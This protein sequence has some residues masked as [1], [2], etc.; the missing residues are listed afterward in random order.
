MTCARC[1]DAE[2]TLLAPCIGR[3]KSSEVY[4]CIHNISQERYAVK[5][6]S[7][8]RSTSREDSIREMRVMVALANAPRTVRPVDFFDE[9]HRCLLVMELL[10]G[11]D[12]SQHIDIPEITASGV[13]KNVLEAL[14]AMHSL[15]IAHRDLKLENVLLTCDDLTNV[16][17]ADFGFAEVVP[18]SG[19]R[20]CSGTPLYIAPEVLLSGYYSQRKCHAATL[21][22]GTAC[23]MWSIGV[24]TYILICGRAPFVGDTLEEHFKRIVAGDV[25]YPATISPRARSFLAGL[26]NIN[27][28]AR[29]TAQRA[30][31]HPWVRL[32]PEAVDDESDNEHD[33]IP[34]VEDTKVCGGDSTTRVWAV[35]FLVSC[36]YALASSL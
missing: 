28:K 34:V 9:P 19:L 27:P 6:V 3:G 13:I 12:L 22:Y 11:G 14:A 25:T 24:M 35:P 16:V 18:E 7:K 21:H 29:F 32:G 30:L 17:L 8:T 20:Q 5:I 33:E 10:R 31:E 36:V 26:L 23:D 4:E 2:Y 15:G 1:F